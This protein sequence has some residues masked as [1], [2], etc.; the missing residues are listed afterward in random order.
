MTASTNKNN[1]HF[2]LPVRCSDIRQAPKSALW[3]VSFARFMTEW[4]CNRDDK[5]IILIHVQ[6]GSMVTG[7]DPCHSVSTS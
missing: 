2:L 4:V 1:E 5:N 3:F 6:F 7:H